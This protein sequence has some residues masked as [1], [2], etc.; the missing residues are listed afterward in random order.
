MRFNL[1]LG[2]K[3][4]KEGVCKDCYKPCQRKPDGTYYTLCNL[5]RVKHMESSKTKRLW[6][7]ENHIC[8]R[9]FKNPAVLKDDGKYLSI[10]EQCRT[11]EKEKRCR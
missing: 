8:S 2:K 11:K 1:T 10:C 7:K 9:C 5:C 3:P 6:A 4:R